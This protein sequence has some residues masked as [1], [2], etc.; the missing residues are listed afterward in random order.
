[1]L[2]S[3]TRRSVA[4]LTGLA[5][6]LGGALILAGC[7]SPATPAAAP[8]AAPATKLSASVAPVVQFAV[9]AKMSGLRQA[10]DD[11]SLK[12]PKSAETFLKG[13]VL[14]PTGGSV[15]AV[16]VAPDQFETIELSAAAGRVVDPAGTLRQLTQ[17]RPIDLKEVRPADPGTA[18]G[19]GTCGVSRDYAP[20]LVLTLCDWAEPGSVGAIRFL[21]LKDRRGMFAEIRAQLQP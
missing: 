9:P 21:S 5:A 8:A 7:G 11:E 15:A 16:Y 1:M 19:V 2:A 6:M 13:K 4:A 20:P 17:A 12:R 3:V 18:G 10:T 14:S